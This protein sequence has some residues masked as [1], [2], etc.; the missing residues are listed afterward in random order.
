MFFWK[1]KKAERF[2][3][4]EGLGVGLVEGDTNQVPIKHENTTCVCVCLILTFGDQIARK[5]AQN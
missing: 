3:G 2:L 5:C 1:C 4:L